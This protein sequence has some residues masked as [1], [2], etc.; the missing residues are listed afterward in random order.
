MLHFKVYL[1]SKRDGII[2]TMTDKNITYID[3][4]HAI[5]SGKYG[6]FCVNIKDFYLG[7]AIFEYG[8][9]SEIEIAYLKQFL[10]SGDHFID[11]GS[12]AGYIAI[13]LAQHVGKNG[14]GYA[15]EPQHY[16]FKMLEKNIA[17]NA[18]KNLTA[19]NHGLSD[20]TSFANK[21]ETENFAEH[22]SYNL[23]GIAFNERHLKHQHADDVS[24]IILDS[25]AIKDPIRLIK[26]DVE[27]MELEVLKG[28]VDLIKRDKPILYLE[29]F[30][31]TALYAYE[32]FLEKLG[33][34]YICAHYPELFNPDNYFKN[35]E[36][37]YGS[38]QSRNALFMHEDEQFVFS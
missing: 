9:Y 38:K 26:I 27:G 11:V 6:N 8:E 17:L 13:P 36:N 32:S 16:L 3:E 18:I 37:I 2:I 23:G 31:K 30:D 5:I 12:H 24:F 34:T 4:F 20:R 28:A 25:L 22:E 10:K 35:S 29:W 14:K 21:S 33:Y 1:I 19:F 7:K 15:F